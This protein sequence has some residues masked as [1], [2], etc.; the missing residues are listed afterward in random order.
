M[1]DPLAETG[2]RAEGACPPAS[3]GA[4]A[5]LNNIGKSSLPHSVGAHPLTWYQ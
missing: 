1:C 4:C 3:V 2:T 5:G